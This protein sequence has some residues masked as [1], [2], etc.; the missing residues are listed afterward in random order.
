MPPDGRPPRAGARHDSERAFGDLLFDQEP[1]VA[2]RGEALRGPCRQTSPQ[3]ERESRRQAGIGFAPVQRE[4]GVNR[5]R[6]RELFGHAVPQDQRFPGQ[7]FVEQASHGP[8]VGAWIGGLPADLLRTHV[9]RRAGHLAGLR[10]RRSDLESNREPEVEDLDHAVVLHHHVRGFEVPMND[11]LRV[12]RLDRAGNLSHQ[13]KRLVDRRRAATQALQQGPALDHF[14]RQEVTPTNVFHGV[15]GGDVR[16]I[17]RGQH[18]RLTEEALARLRVAVEVR[19]EHLQR[20]L[21]FEARI[22]R[23]I[24]DAH[25]STPQLAEN[26]IGADGVRHR[27]PRSGRRSR[28]SR[29][30]TA[31][32]PRGIVRSR[33]RAVWHALTKAE[34]MP[35][36]KAPWPL[37]IAAAPCHS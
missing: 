13:G 1:H 7:A 10:C 5:Q 36:R 25:A 8:D 33:R 6:G 28:G 9:A 15:D 27:G 21:A 34:A 37:R 20:H 29:R 11:S 19:R 26:R 3:D 14:H 32:R 23:E 17:E 4:L 22:A 16:V 24:D 35:G 31:E 12:R 30:R 2:H 18:A